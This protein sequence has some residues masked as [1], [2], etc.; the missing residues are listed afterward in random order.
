HRSIRENIVYGAG[1][2]VSGDELE[3]AARRA[4]AHEFIVGTDQGYDTLVGERG[5]R[6]STGQRQRIALARA[7]LCAA[8]ILVLDEATSALD[9][10]SE[11][12]VQ[13][14]LEE[15]WATRTVIAIAHRL[16]TLLTMD[17]IVVLDRGRITEEGT[18]RELLAR[19][20]LYHHLWCQQSGGLIGAK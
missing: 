12:L 8:P 18:H 20:G 5:I 19:G 4:H 10:E 1:V 17:R 11:R 15:L 14:A 13:E 6:L 2:A 7:F 3:S 16:S 9:S